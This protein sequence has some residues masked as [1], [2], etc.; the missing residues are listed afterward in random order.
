MSC[1]TPPRW[2]RGFLL[3]SNVARPIPTLGLLLT[4]AA[5]GAWFLGA[6]L[7]VHAL[8]LWAIMAPRVQWLGPVVSRFGATEKVV[9]LTIDDGPAGDSTRGL[10]SALRERGVPATFF[11]I[12]CRLRADPGTA[13]ILQ[14]DGHTLANHSATHPRKSFW[15]SSR[16]MARREVDEGKSALRE[17]GI[18]SPWFRPPVG[19]KPPGLHGILRSRR[20]QLVSWEAGG[21]D[22]WSSDPSATV[23]RV[24]AKVRPGSIILLH[25][26]RAY[27][28][29]TIL[30]VVDSLLAIG[31]RFIIPEPGQL[32]PAIISST[33][34]ENASAVGATQS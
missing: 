2:W 29:E 10:S 4:G 15:C 20:L 33:D 6:T 23:E 31:Y 5:G 25:E 32:A 13:A 1:R 24:R 14:Q 11:V 18:D 12:G 16:A 3:A 7:L 22:G 21:R 34:L 30:A 19:H 27:S 8:L 17:V 28:R 9:W 26:G